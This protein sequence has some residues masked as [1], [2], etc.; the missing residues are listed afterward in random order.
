MRRGSRL[1]SRI[2]PIHPKIR[3]LYGAQSIYPLESQANGVY[4]FVFNDLEL[5]CT[6][7]RTVGRP[8]TKKYGPFPVISSRYLIEPS[9]DQV[10]HLGGNMRRTR[11]SLFVLMRKG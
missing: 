10:G 6:K 5:A 2:F 9:L 7:N 8:I 3:D 11:E 1:S 4:A